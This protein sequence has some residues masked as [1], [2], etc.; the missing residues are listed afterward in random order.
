MIWHNLPYS[1]HTL[2]L[3]L[4]DRLAAFSLPGKQLSELITSQRNLGTVARETGL[5]PRNF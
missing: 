1:Q 5:S 3:S 2:L 4:P